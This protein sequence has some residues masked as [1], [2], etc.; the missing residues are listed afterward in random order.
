MRGTILIAGDLAPTESNLNFFES[1]DAATL[2]GEE[3]FYLWSEVD[4]R[5]F[6]LELPLVD[7][8][9]PIEKC[10]P[11]LIAPTKSMNGIKALNPSLVTLANNHILDQGEYGLKSTEQLLIQ[12]HIPYV[13]A[14][15][16]LSE[17]R[18]PYILNLN[19]INVGVYACAEHEF[20][21][22]TDRSPGANPFDPLE[23]LDDIQLLKSKCDY[24]IVLY[25]GGKEHYRYPSP[26][27]QKICRKIAAKGADLIVCQ[28]SHCIGCIEQFESSTIIYGQGNFLF[29]YTDNE[30]WKTSIIIKIDIANGINIEYIPIIKTGNTIR[31]ANSTEKKEILDSMIFRSEEIKQDGFIEQSYE[32]FAKRMYS[33]YLVGM[34]GNNLV[35]RVFNKLSRYKFI[36]LLYSK[37]SLLWIR[38]I[39][40]CE[41]HR[42]LFLSHLRR[43]K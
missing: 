33:E 3:L 32:R 41:A 21:I 29:D 36:N 39:I 5:I 31:I 22:A 1:G 6:N 42:E 19:G 13:G 18:K 14:G 16:R 9:T 11:N 40:E 27:L 34:S 4:V 8:A 30:Y 12:H 43:G 26:N 7:H 28:H 25:H 24:V 15:D 10:G 23:S 37:R 2:L 20:T 38:N 35:L 17:A